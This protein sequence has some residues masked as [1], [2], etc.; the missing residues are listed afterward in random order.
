[1]S[2]LERIKNTLPV[3]NSIS[4]TFCLAKW[5][6]SQI[7]LQTGHTHSCYHP[8]PHKIPLE[9]LDSNPSLLHNTPIK[10][11]ERLSMLK[12]EKPSGCQYCWNVEKLGEDYVSDRHIRNSS[13]YTKERLDDILLHGADYN[14]NPE[15]IELSFS[16]QCNFKCGYCH[17]TAS[18]R[19]NAEIREFG[20]YDSVKNHR[21]EPTGYTVFENEDENPYV[22]AWW[23]WWDKMKHTL[24]ILRITGGEPLM[25]KSTWN[26]LDSLD[27]EPLPHLELNMNSNL[28]GKNEWVERLG[29]TVSRLI[30]QKKIKQFKLWT[31][32]DTWGPRAEYIRTGLDLA[33]WEQNLDTYIKTTK[34]PITFM[35]TFNILSVTTFPLLLEKILEW[36]AKYDEFIPVINT[37]DPT[38]RKIR[39]DTPY[40]K[41]PLQYDM[42]ILPLEDYLPYMDKTLEFLKNNMDDSDVTKFSSL[43]YEKFRRVRDY[44]A[45]SSANENYSITKIKEGRADFYNWFCEFDYRRNTNFLETF[46]EMIN[47]WKMCEQE[48]LLR[49]IG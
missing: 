27:S 47:F 8:P 29:T 36:R 33:V 3:I 38:E 28:G 13:I 1:M 24:N 31:S 25:H 32:I 23:D 19:F 16:N 2:D 37:L 11:Q 10:K 18:S 21:L 9:G 35:C 43:E 4:P 42:N 46:P 30:K 39:F 41:E 40:L 17:P 20:P 45:S 49:K 22:K 34:S 7:Y 12:G 48:S 15:Y 5:H 14:I 6:H 44:M 26:L